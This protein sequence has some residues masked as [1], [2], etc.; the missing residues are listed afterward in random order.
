MTIEEI[1]KMF[2]VF[3]IEKGLYG[4]YSKSDIEEWVDKYISKPKLKPRCC[5]RCDGVDDICVTD[6]KCESH[7]VYG[8]EICFGPKFVNAE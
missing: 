3:R 8:C 6:T 2:E 7:G 5:G 1:K 4:L